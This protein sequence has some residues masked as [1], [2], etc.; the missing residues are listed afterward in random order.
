MEARGF[1]HWHGPD[2]SGPGLAFAL[3]AVNGP[4][5]GQ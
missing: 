3:H 5:T 2:K 4:A 1:S